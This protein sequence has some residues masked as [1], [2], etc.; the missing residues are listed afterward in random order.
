MPD[1][2]WLACCLAAIAWMASWGCLLG[3]E[4]VPFKSLNCRVLVEIS[5]SPDEEVTGTIFSVRTGDAD[6]LCLSLEPSRLRAPIVFR[7]LQLVR[8]KPVEGRSTEIV[9][10][11]GSL[12]VGPGLFLLP[13]DAPFGKLLWEDIRSLPNEPP[14]FSD[15]TPTYRLVLKVRLLDVIHK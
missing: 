12:G 5:G 3:D 2:R 7:R 8:A 13:S 6:S 10:P 14:G 11:G 1:R 15:G 9:V 4:V